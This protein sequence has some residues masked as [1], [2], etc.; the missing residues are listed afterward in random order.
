[1]V[2]HKFISFKVRKYAQLMQHLQT[3]VKIFIAGS[4]KIF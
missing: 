4:V 2:E 1:M 3:F